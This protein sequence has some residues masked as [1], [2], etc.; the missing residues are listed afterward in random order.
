MICSAVRGS[1]TPR[2]SST[3]F[4]SVKASYSVS[5]QLPPGLG[6]PVGMMAITAFTIPQVAFSD[7]ETGRLCREP[8]GTG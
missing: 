3:F 6:A 1:A 7:R 5:I 8:T 2:T 4:S